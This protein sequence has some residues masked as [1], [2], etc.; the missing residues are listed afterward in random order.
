MTTTPILGLPLVA[1]QQD[2]PE[3]THNEAL[4]LLQALAYG[5]VQVGLNT[6][7]SHSDGSLWVVGAAP[8]G[9][10]TGRA[11]SIAGSFGGSWYFL[12][13]VD[14][15]GSPIAMGADQEGMRVW[16][17]TDNCAFVWT[18]GG[19]VA[20]GGAMRSYTVAEVGALAATGPFHF[21][22]VSNESGG[23]VPAFNDGVNWR[24][25]TDRAIVS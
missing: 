21:V 16:S 25:V 24:R 23:A 9:A 6:P 14:D 20:E 2:Q 17:K 1:N 22:Y 19:W 18:G 11:N 8:T 5:V 3:V 10:W 13:F 12:P 7:A 4:Q 15:D